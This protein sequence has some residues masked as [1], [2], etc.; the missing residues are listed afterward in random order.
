MAT[1]DLLIRNGQIVDGTG[2]PSFIADLAIRDGHIAEIAP[3]IDAADA[4]ET[5]DADGHIVTPGWIDPHTHFD[6]QATWDD[7]MDPVFGHGTTTVVMGNCGV[8]F[9]PIRPGAQ[10]ELI[11]I[12]EGVEDIPFGALSEAIPWGS[13]E[14]YPEYLAY[15]DQRSYTIDIGSQ[16]PHGALRAYVMG[17]DNLFDK[18]ASPEEIER[19]AALVGEAVEAGALGVSTSRVIGHR[20]MSGESVPGTYA[21][22]HE[23]TR[24]A[25]AMARV[26]RGVLQCIP[27]GS[28]GTSGGLY[29]DPQTTE[30][31]MSM[32]A[33]I[34]RSTGRPVTFT[35]FQVPEA[36]HEYR[37]ILDRATEENGKGAQLHPQ[38]AAR[39][40]GILVS[41]GGYHPLMR[42]ETYLKIAHLPLAERVAEMRK[43]EM[44]AAILSDK[45]MLDAGAGAAENY[46]VQYLANLMGHL[47]PLGEQVDYEP[48]TARFVS[49][50][51]RERGDTDQSV[52]YDSL[53]ELDGA[54]VLMLALTNYV[55]S[56]LNAAREMFLHPTTVSGLGDAGAHCKFICDASIPTFVLSHYVRDRTR[57]DRIPIEQ[58]V[59]KL[60]AQTADVYGLNDRGRLQ[61]G[62]RGD[63][64]IIDMEKIGIDLP[65]MHWD[66]P[67]GSGRLLQ[68]A[69]GYKA[70]LV[71]GVVTRRDGEDTGARPG[72]LVRPS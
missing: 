64:N 51:A 41:L 61:A 69:R 13:W 27:G 3:G 4:H 21:S 19:M 12:M 54:N 52:V 32:L 63:I 15:L 67:L 7:K 26:G 28:F 58:A 40:P 72:R 70:T 49:A 16:I 53:L 20:A 33:R 39:P 66:M 5:I 44:K 55:D 60:S 43:P 1:Y 23:L 65:R 24:F 42:R 50:I 38:I 34:S 68:K 56:N 11:D 6:G 8:G 18:Q 59:A 9:A 17:S 45:D 46:V 31:E 71:K 35:T 2:A 37:Y 47:V 36:P 48:D 14:S 25:E 62:K 57:G 30:Q 22:E 29:V 10:N